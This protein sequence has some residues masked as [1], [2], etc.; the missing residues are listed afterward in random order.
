MQQQESQMEPCLGRGCRRMKI[1]PALCGTL[2]RHSQPPRMH[3]RHARYQRFIEISTQDKASDGFPLLLARI[4][5]KLTTPPSSS[6]IARPMYCNEGPRRKTQQHEALAHL[7]GL[8]PITHCPEVLDPFSRATYERTI[9][10][11]DMIV[12]LG[13][14]RLDITCP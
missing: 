4:H 3:T 8:P 7:A 12:S 1:L 9:P 11:V 5:N 10:S 13:T 6:L 14:L 2:S